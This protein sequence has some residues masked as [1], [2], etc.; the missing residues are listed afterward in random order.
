MCHH[1]TEYVPATAKEVTKKATGFTAS[2]GMELVNVA[3]EVVALFQPSA[4]AQ[5]RAKSCGE[6][7]P[8]TS[9]DFP[10]RVRRVMNF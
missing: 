6:Q 5:G 3:D 7:K 8:L 1:S 4:K 10:L 2:P 9:A